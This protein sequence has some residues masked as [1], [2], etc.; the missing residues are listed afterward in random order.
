M[1]MDNQP[2]ADRAAGIAGIS[3][4]P[5]LIDKAE[6][7]RMVCMR[8]S[9]FYAEVAAG[10]LPPPIRI[11]RSSRY[12]KSEYEDWLRELVAAARSKA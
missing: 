3:E 2:I 5:E 7:M 11:G 8:H 12:V 4:V 9:K 6:A 10:R 1:T